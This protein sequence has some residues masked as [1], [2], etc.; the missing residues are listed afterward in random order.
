MHLGYIHAVTLA[1]LLSHIVLG[2]TVFVSTNVDDILLLALFFADDRLHPRTV[3]L[4]QFAGIGALVLASAAAALA[5]FAAPEGWIALLGVVP[6][7]LGLFK[8]F[9]AWRGH[10]ESDE[11]ELHIDWQRRRRKRCPWRP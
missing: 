9:E 11:R 2:I 1:A 7:S 3:V 10:R 6:L 4:G 5:A 8:L